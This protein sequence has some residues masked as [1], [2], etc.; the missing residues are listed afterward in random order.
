MSYKKIMTKEQLAPVI[1]SVNEKGGVTKTSLTAVLS[2]IL[3]VMLKRKV[4]VIG[5]DPQASI[6][7]VF[8]FLRETIPNGT[9][10][11]DVLQGKCTIVQAIMKTTIDPNTMAFYDHRAFQLEAGGS[12]LR[13]PDLVPLNA[14]GIGADFTLKNLED[15][16]EL[17]REALEPIRAHYDY[18]FIDCAPSLGALTSNAITAATHV[19]IPIVPER[20]VVEGVLGLLGAIKQAKRKR[21]PNLIIAGFILSKVHANW[22][23]HK[24]VAHELKELAEQNSDLQDLHLKVFQTVIKENAEFE[25]SLGRHSLIVL[26]NAES[27]YARAYWYV[28]H[29]LLQTVGGVAQADL[30]LVVPNMKKDD[31]RREKERKEKRLGKEREQKK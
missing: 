28:L 21:N 4:L 24:T 14:S 17:L 9:T 27:D 22:K 23:S 8:G 2:A 3:S 13:G 26:D 15:W 18:I 31:Q 12:P 29:E 19:C 10:L 11:F 20:L 7:N 16:S 6:E 25:V 5:A 30:E 1:I